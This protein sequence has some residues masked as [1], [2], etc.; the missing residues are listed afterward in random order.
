MCVARKREFL[1]TKARAEELR[2]AE[3]E[4][5]K[6]TASSTEPASATESLSSARP[7]GSARGKGVQ[8][9]LVDEEHQSDVAE[10]GTEAADAEATRRTR[11]MTKNLEQA[12]ASVDA[13]QH[14][15]SAGEACKNS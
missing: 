8:P 1:L 14:V 10:A 12:L 11:I 3:A 9:E 2:A 15:R 7:S 13:G 5:W 6:K 4:A